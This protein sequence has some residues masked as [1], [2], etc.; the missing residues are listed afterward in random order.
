MYRPCRCTG[1]TGHDSALA[2]DR[3]AIHPMSPELSV[4][5]NLMPSIQ[6]LAYIHVYSEF[7]AL[8]LLNL[9]MI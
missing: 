5:H 3:A 1:T 6:Q 4:D 2:S 9:G 8:N 7:S